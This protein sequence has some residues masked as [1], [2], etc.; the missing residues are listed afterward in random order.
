MVQVVGL[1]PSATA[2]LTVIVLSVLDGLDKVSRGFS[3]VRAVAVPSAPAPAALTACTR[4]RTTAPSPRPVRVAEVPV[5]V[6]DRP[7]ADTTYPVTRR[8]LSAAAPQVTV[9]APAGA[10]TAAAR[11]SGGADGAAYGTTVLLTGDG[12][13]L[14]PRSFTAT[15]LNAYWVPNFSGAPAPARTVML[16]VSVVSAWAGPPVVIGVTSYRRT[17]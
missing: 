8:P 5:T 11:R 15:T 17:L 13:E 4:T 16:A 12:L 2:K 10:G 7:L 6:L 1:P 9:T 3:M 14:A